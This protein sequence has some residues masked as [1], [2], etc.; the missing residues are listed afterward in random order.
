[1]NGEFLELYDRINGRLLEIEK[2]QD[3]RHEENLKTLGKLKCRTHAER[4]KGHTYAIGFL[5]T[6][7]FLSILAGII[8]RILNGAG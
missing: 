6:F 7:I 4:M 1:M 2:K 5:Y 8:A 3:S